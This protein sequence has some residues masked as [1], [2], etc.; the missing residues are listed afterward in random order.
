VSRPG[1][2]LPPGKTRY[3]LY[4]RLGGPQGRSGQVQKILSPPGFDPRTVQPVGSRYTNCATRPGSN[5][6]NSY[7][8]LS[9]RTFL[10]IVENDRQLVHGFAIL[11][12]CPFTTTQTVR[13][14]FCSVSKFGA[15]IAIRQAAQEIWIAVR[16]CYQHCGI[17]DPF[18]VGVSSSSAGTFEVQTVRGRRAT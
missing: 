15:H 1:R 18:R 6:V 3:P 17:A 8:L 10:K 11:M 2:T 4:R 16:Q 9:P 14:L 12:V 5:T 13:P 7:E